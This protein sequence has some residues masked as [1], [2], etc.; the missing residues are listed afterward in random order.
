ME[1]GL[2]EL[3]AELQSVSGAQT[4]ELAKMR[5]ALRQTQALLQKASLD[6]SI[7]EDSV[8]NR[9]ERIA[10]LEGESEADR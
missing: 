1:I 5:V 3:V 4:V 6:L 2:D 7:A 9:D 8:K 10:E